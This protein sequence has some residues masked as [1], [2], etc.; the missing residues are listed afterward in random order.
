MGYI[1]PNVVLNRQWI[2]HPAP[3]SRYL[4]RK[5]ETMIHGPSVKPSSYLRDKAE[6]IE[7]DEQ[8]CC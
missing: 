6:T 2:S 5:G 7:P 1:L 3:G 8:Y 4:L